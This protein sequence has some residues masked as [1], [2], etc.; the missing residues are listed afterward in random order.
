MSP[1]R[2]Q[3]SLPSDQTSTIARVALCG[4]NVKRNAWAWPFH[5]LQWQSSPLVDGVKCKSDPRAWIWDLLMYVRKVIVK[6]RNSSST[7]SGLRTVCLRQ[8]TA[9]EA[10]HV[11]KGVKNGGTVMSG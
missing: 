9:R 6:W 1:S 7:F 3:K 5:L 11:A 8:S 4:K 2:T 10:R